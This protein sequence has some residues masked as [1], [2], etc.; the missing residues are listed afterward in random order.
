MEL[1]P[2]GHYWL[3]SGIP[4]IVI[5]TSADGQTAYVRYDIVSKKPYYS[6]IDASLLQEVDH[7]EAETNGTL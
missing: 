3:P 7:G 4:V 5:A 2:G 1:Q 6:K